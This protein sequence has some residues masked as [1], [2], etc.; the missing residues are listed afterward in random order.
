[1]KMDWITDNELEIERMEKY[2]KVEVKAEDV[3]KAVSEWIGGG[4]ILAVRQRQGKEYKV[5]LEKEETCEEPMDGLTT[6][7][8]NCEVKK[9]LQNREY[10][11]SFMHLPIYLED[12]KIGEKLEGW[13]FF[14]ISIIKRRLYMG[15]NIEDGTRYVKVRFPREVVSLPYSTNMETAEG[16][17]YCRVMHSCQV[18]TCWLCMSPEHLLRDYPDFKCFKCGE[19]GHFARDCNTVKCLDCHEFLNRCECWME[20]QEGGEESQMDGQMHERINQKRNN[21][22]EQEERNRNKM[23]QK[24]NQTTERKEKK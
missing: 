22:E 7:G 10:V 21:D 12:E 16:Q 23:S 24:R 14:P 17:Q 19:R 5:T 1:M 20:E 18:K 4:N 15:T 11:V 9:P 6:K 3:I 2:G 8:T 13:G